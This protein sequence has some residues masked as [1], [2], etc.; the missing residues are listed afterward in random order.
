MHRWAPLNWEERVAP[1]RFDMLV[2]AFATGDTRRRLMEAL[3]ALSLVGVLTGLPADGAVAEC[4]RDR[5][6]RRKD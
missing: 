1:R 3:T 6:Q 2:R 4:P 5:L